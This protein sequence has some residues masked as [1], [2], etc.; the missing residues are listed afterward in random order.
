MIRS[1]IDLPPSPLPEEGGENG[2]RP[3]SAPVSGSRPLGAARRGQIDLPPNPLPE[4]GGEN[5]SRPATAPAPGS[6]AQRLVCRFLLALAGGLAALPA[7]A[8]LPA[9]ASFEHR[10]QAVAQRLPQAFGDARQRVDAAYRD[11]FGRIAPELLAQRRQEEFTRLA[12]QEASTR[13]LITRLGSAPGDLAQAEGEL[14]AVEALL[15]N[16]LVAPAP[17]PRAAARGALPTPAKA[18]PF[19]FPP[20]PAP[21]AADLAAT[22]DAPLTPAL[23]AQAQALNRAPLAIYNWVRGNIAYLPGRG[24]QLGAAGTFAARRGNA[25]DQASLLIALLRAADVPA[26]FATGEVELSASRLREWLGVADTATALDL[27]R[28]SG[29]APYASYAGGQIA[30]VRFQHAWVQAW[31]DVWPSRGAVHRQGDAWVLLDP[32]YKLQTRQGGFDLASALGLDANALAAQLT[33]AATGDWSRG[34]LDALDRSVAAQALSQV[35]QRLDAFATQNRLSSLADL[36]GQT[37]LEAPAWPLLPLALPYTVTAQNFAGPDL[38]AGERQSLRLRVYADA[39]ARLR[40]EALWSEAIDWPALALGQLSWRFVPATPADAQALRALLGNAAT[41]P[42]AINPTG[43]Q[44][45]LERLRDG[46]AQ[47]IAGPFALGRALV[48]DFTLSEPGRDPREIAFPLI[49]GETRHWGWDLAGVEG[50]RLASVAALP[51]STLGLVANGLPLLRQNVAGLSAALNG[52]ARV[53]VPGL[54]GAYTWLE[55]ELAL[56]VAVK[57]HLTGLAVQEIG[58]DDPVAGGNASRHRWQ[59]AQMAAQLAGSLPAQL[60]GQGISSAAAFAA[61][62]QA[63]QAVWTLDAAQSTTLAQ[64]QLDKVLET[65][66]ADALAAGERVTV[67]GAETQLADWAGRGG[68]QLETSSGKGLGFAFGAGRTLAVNGQAVAGGAYGD[69]GALLAWASWVDPALLGPGA[70]QLQAQSTQLATNL[71][72]QHGNFLANPLSPA[73]FGLIG[74][75]TIDSQAGPRTPV[76]AQLPHFG[77]LAGPGL[78]ALVSDTPAP[79]VTLTLDPTAIALGQSSALTGS[80]QTVKPLVSLTATLAGESAALSVNG[81][82]FQARLT[83]NRSGVLKVEVRAE[84]SK[85]K[86]G[87]ASATLAVNDPANT[88][89]PVVRLTAPADNAEL[90][91]RTV[92]RGEVSSTALASWQLLA[93]P[94]G[95]VADD[96]PRWTELAAGTQNT[97]GELG[98]FDPSLLPNGLWH[99]QLVATDLAYRQSRSLITVEV[100]GGAKP[101]IFTVSFLDLEVEAGGIPIRVTR[102]YDSRRKNEALDFGYGW[103]VDTQHLKLQKNMATGLHWT[104]APDPGNRLALCL[105]PAGKRKINIT[106]PEGRVERFE[107][108][109]ANECTQF[110]A[111]L[112]DIDFVALT[113]TTSTLTAIN[114]PN[115]AVQGGMI[116]DMD[117]LEPWN[118]KEFKLTTQEGYAYYLQENLGITRIQDPWGNTLDYTAHGIVHSNGQSVSFTRDGQG[119]IVAITDPTGKTIRY[120]YTSAGDLTSLT[121]RLSQTTTLAYDIKHPHLLTTF[122]DPRGIQLLKNVYDDSGRLIAQYDAQGERVDLARRDLDARQQTVVNRRGASTRYQYDERGNVTQITDAYG[123]VTSR[124]YDAQDN[125]LTVTDPLGHSTSHTY[126]AVTQQKTT[127]TDPLGHRTSY[128]YDQQHNL[129]QTTDALDRVTQYTHDG[130]ALTQLT[131]PLGQSTRFAYDAKGNLL[132]LTDPLGNKTSYQYDAQGRKTQETDAGGLTTKFTLDAN[133]H[134]TQESRAVTTASGKQTL[135]TQK[136]LDANGRILSETDPLGAVR[137]TTW[138][139]FDQPATETDPLNRTTTHSYS[140]RAERT[141]TTYPDGTQEAF[142]YDAEGNKIAHTDRAGRSTQYVYDLLNRLTQTVYPDGATE[143]NEYDAAGRLIGSTDPLGRKT[144]FAYDAAGRK[145]SATDPLGQITRYAYNEVNDLTSVTAPDGA[146]TRYEYDA[147]HRRT[148]TTY[149][150]GSKEAVAYDAAGRRTQLTAADGAVTKFAYDAMGRLTSVTDPLNKTTTYAYDELGR[151]TSQ[152]DALGRVTKFEY[153]EASRLA[154]KT[155]PNGAVEKFSYDLAGNLVKH[156]LFDQTNI[157]TTVDVNDRPAETSL[158]E[159]QT[160]T[161]SYT[162]TGQVAS[163]TDAHGTT[164]YQYDSRDRL[165]QVEL[166]IGVIL[167]YAYDAAGNRSEVTIKTPAANGK[168]AASYATRYSFDA[169]NRLATV[170]SPTGEVTSFSYDAAGRRSQVTRPFGINTAYAYDSAGRLKT[171][172]HAKGATALASFEVKRDAAGRITEQKETLSGQIKTRRFA[173]DTAGKLIDD[174]GSA[175]TYDAVGNRITG[176]QGAAVFD[177]N[178]RLAN[179]GS[180]TFTWDSNGRLTQQTS[181]TETRE[182]TWNSLDRLLEVKLTPQGQAAQVTQY[183]YDADDHRIGITQGSGPN[184]QTTQLIVD[185]N[186]T[187]AQVIAE[188]EAQT[189]SI[190]A[191][192]TLGEDLLQLSRAGQG[193]FYHRV[194]LTDPLGAV[195]LL[196]DEAANITDS[197]TYDAWGNVTARTGSTPNPYKFQGEWQEESAG[198]VYLR[199]RWYDPGVGRFLSVDPWQGEKQRPVSLNRFLYVGA[200]PVDGRDPSGRVEVSFAGIGTAFNGAMAM[201]TAGVRYGSVIY[202]RL[203][204]KALENALAGFLRTH[205]PTGSLVA[206]RLLTGPGGPRVFDILVKYRD[207]IVILEVKTGIP[208]G[209]GAFGRLLG[210]IKTFSAPTNLVER[211][212]VGTVERVIVVTAEEAVA[213]EATSARV[214][215]ELGSSSGPTVL[216]GAMNLVYELRTILSIL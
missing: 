156:T 62:V 76:P 33:A 212:I 16:R 15:D 2:S 182:F 60:G 68:A 162:A 155:L 203:A 164:T 71:A 160:V 179:Q 88:T 174:D 108:K 201:A 34:R 17:R 54:A 19:V 121:D 74:G 186:R 87:L 23:R 153:D 207:K 82:T 116:Y 191:L 209:G 154:Q 40:D 84:D 211:G 70:N 163:V 118:P 168:P 20:L 39:L 166:P 67:S 25:W 216:N 83:P 161:R 199:A 152:T 24:S 10:R 97:Q 204:G 117:A 150:D 26:R 104:V 4:E 127:D 136:T 176:P 38:P 45:Q 41:P 167:S 138:T 144:S 111:P 113:G 49:A 105:K 93:A 52:S 95:T 100:L 101:G 13:D 58:S 124:S 8:A 42:K 9:G 192:Y 55:P 7:F 147:N 59:V 134:V 181:P 28:Q 14:A 189:Q 151:Q 200:D 75:L 22:V 141:A 18:A 114:L 78:S 157:S 210:Q 172:T 119:R 194:P 73:L 92:V 72:A 96:L 126:D 214:L 107:A 90:T 196:V 132:S 185:A 149:P 32:A 158:P 205:L 36:L 99:L 142:G 135:I 187:Y 188:R 171:L 137:Q 215:T 94:A 85:G 11:Q 57:L 46:Q 51:Q 206:Q 27:L 125:E 65:R 120:R 21:T 79:Q 122:T 133:G 197:Y 3:A 12:V 208:A 56:G 175:F 43:I 89:A 183:A 128:A 5:G 145:T 180:T 131:D 123:K 146:I 61:N 80:V 37:R 44:V 102:T 47:P 50:G 198:L 193:T 30:S 63:G 159:G 184:A 190:A 170:T 48:A 98:A 178:D 64:L 110:Q 91:L 148:Q 195:R 69:L 140:E 86:V 6:L 173:Y 202:N 165:T 129:T 77:L 169:D 81:D 53:P 66:L 109:A 103:S 29:Q 112:P 213:I 143:Q 115:L 35:T 130:R 31:V 106:L 139:P 1:Q 177:A